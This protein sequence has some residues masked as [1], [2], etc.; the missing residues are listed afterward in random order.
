MTTA[1]SGAGSSAGGAGGNT[2]ESTGAPQVRWL[3]GYWESGSP[4]CVLASARTRMHAHTV[5]A[6]T[7][8]RAH[9]H[10][11]SLTHTHTDT[12]VHA[13]SQQLWTHI[14]LP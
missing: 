14:T 11:L 1:A 4:T 9:T 3:C 5:R 8:A 6:R 10:S 7:H 2:P 12:H 13:V